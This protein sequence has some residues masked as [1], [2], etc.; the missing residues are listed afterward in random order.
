MSRGATGTSACVVKT[1]A[2]PMG[3]PSKVEITYTV[4]P[5][6]RL[7][8]WTA[9]PHSYK[10]LATTGVGREAG[11]GST[12]TGADGALQLVQSSC[13]AVIRAL[14]TSGGTSKSKVAAGAEP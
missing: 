12:L 2:I 8:T 14:A 9:A 10:G 1:S 5:G 13:R 4:A 3:A 11:F 7:L 6:W